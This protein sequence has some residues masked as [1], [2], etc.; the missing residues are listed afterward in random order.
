MTPEDVAAAKAVKEVLGIYDGADYS[1]SGKE[2]AAPAEGA[3]AKAA[4][5]EGASAKAAPADEELPPELNPDAT[6]PALLTQDKEVKKA[7]A[8]TTPAANAN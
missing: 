1:K 7:H 8:T 3:P 6:P 2:G 4:P 5:A